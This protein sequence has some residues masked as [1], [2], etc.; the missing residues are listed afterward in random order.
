M[1]PRPEP[2]GL[3]ERQE[4]MVESIEIET[5]P[6]RGQAHVA[7]ADKDKA[8]ELLEDV[9]H[10]VVLTPENNSR[11]LRKIDMR[12]LPIIL[13]IYFLQSLDKTTLA[14]ASVFGL[15]EKTHLVGLQ[16]SWLG[17]IVYLAQLVVQPL[18]SYILA[19]VPLGKFLAISVF[20]WGAVLSCMTAAHNFVGLLLCRMFLGAFEAGIG[21][22]RL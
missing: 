7:F 13:A 1:S 9:G 14:Y 20:L 4:Q 8:V 16:Y 17:S 5:A 2:S 18:L 11:V 3:K 12:I 15:V 19:K 10:S 22:Y 21:T 6:P